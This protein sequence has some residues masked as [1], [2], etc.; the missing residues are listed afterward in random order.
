MNETVDTFI[1]DAYHREIFTFGSEVAGL[2]LTLCYKHGSEAWQ[3][4]DI[5]TVTVGRF[6]GLDQSNTGNGADQAVE[7]LFKRFLIRG[8][9]ISSQDSVKWVHEDELSCEVDPSAS[10]TVNEGGTIDLKFSSATSADTF[11]KIWY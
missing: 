6:D 4:Y 5:F 9:G 10:A 3:L 1:L 11:L 7:G 8:E 2:T